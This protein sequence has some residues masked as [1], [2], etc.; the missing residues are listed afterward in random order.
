M[1]ATSTGNN[2]SK[3]AKIAEILGLLSERQKGREWIIQEIK[4][5]KL[6]IPT[7][8]TMNVYDILKTCKADIILELLRALK[9]E[10]FDLSF[11]IPVQTRT[12]HWFYTDI[13]GSSHPTVLTRD[14]ARKVWA[15]N[16]LI[17]RT[18]TFKQRDP[19]YDVMTITGDGG[20]RIQ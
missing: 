1:K 18:E 2:S 3:L 8:S 16:E 20:H 12:F 13:V 4:K 9:N 15:L 5:R 17:G 11:K 6:K 19:K 7:K 14:Q 10:D